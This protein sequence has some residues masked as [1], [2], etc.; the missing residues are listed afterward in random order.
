MKVLLI[1]VSFKFLISFIVP[2]STVIL[3]PLSKVEVD[4]NTTITFSC[5]VYGCRP[6]ANIS[7]YGIDNKIVP[8]TPVS[9]PN[10]SLFDVKS[11]LTISFER[12]EIGKTIYCTA[13]NIKGDEPIK[14]RE[15]EIDVKCEYI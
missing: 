12:N 8:T 10:G 14:S 4:E 15:A 13:N 2:V 7:W 1:L 6:K 9:Q 5:L 3:S 11:T